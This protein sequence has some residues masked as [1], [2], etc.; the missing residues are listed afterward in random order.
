[1][2]PL[3]SSC[4]SFLEF[5]RDGKKA[6]E[7]AV[8]YVPQR[9]RRMDAPWGLSSAIKREKIRTNYELPE[10]GTLLTNL[11]I[12]KPVENACQVQFQR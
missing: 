5:A 2:S 11:S 10:L 3:F 12:S 4:G 7:L 9:G 1:M 8:V 6:I